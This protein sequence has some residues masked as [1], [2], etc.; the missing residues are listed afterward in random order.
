MLQVFRR[1]DRP[2]PM[3]LATTPDNPSPPNA[4]EADIRAADGVRL[5]TARWAPSSPARGTI[6]VFGGRGEFIEKY[7]EVIGELLSRGFAV[8]A[9]DWRGQGGSDRALRNARKGHVD[10]FSHYERDLSAF[11]GAVLEPHCPQ[12]WFALGHSMGAAVLLTAAQAGRC[13]FER[14]VLTSPMI[15]VK[16]ANHR[17]VAPFFAEA[18]DIFGLGGAFLP[19]GDGASLWSGPFAGNVLTSDA[20]RFGRIARVVEVAPGLCLGA[21]TIGWVHAAFRCLKRFDEPNFPRATSAPILIVAA[22]ADRVTDTAAAERFASRL[23]GG[24][25][26]V[27]DGAQHEIMFERDV[28]RAQFWSAF[29]QFV[30]GS[31]ALGRRS[32]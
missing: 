23:P 1:P 32:A 30:P 15:A 4:V 19:G 13:P 27:I 7:F 8:A 20:A 11:I 5:R 22:G 26:V 24:S 12:P 14:L 18:L 29:D 31:E 2:A 10:D 16:G 21:P 6:A 28:L 17:G 9:M 3:T 25:I